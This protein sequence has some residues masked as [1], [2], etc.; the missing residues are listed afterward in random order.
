MALA[1]AAA[2]AGRAYHLLLCLM[3]LWPTFR[4]VLLVEEEFI[5][6]TLRSPF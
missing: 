1:P 5:R 3:P 4:R 2:T 6:R